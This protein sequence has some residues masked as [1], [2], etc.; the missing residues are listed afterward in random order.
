[1]NW[2]DAIGIFLSLMCLFLALH[3]LRKPTALMDR[4]AAGLSAM[5]AWLTMVTVTHS[6]HR[7]IGALREQASTVTDDDV[8]S[9]PGTLFR[10]LPERDQTEWLASKKHRP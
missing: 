6:Q 8:F 1:M 10:E 5:V 2:I 4:R 3:E 9:E 7:Q